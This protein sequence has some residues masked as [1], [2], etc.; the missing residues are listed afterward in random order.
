MSTLQ[1]S[2]C[3]LHLGQPHL[4]D[5]CINIRL[6]M[7]AVRTVHPSFNK[8]II[9][10]LQKYLSKQNKLAWEKYRHLALFSEFPTVLCSS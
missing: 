5:A 10:L 9:Y 6:Q 3:Q 8:K 2:Y 1:L 4:I 7:A